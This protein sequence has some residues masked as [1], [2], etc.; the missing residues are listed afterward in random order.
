MAQYLPTAFGPRHLSFP[1]EEANAGYQLD[2]M[3]QGSRLIC[4]FTKQI[5]HGLTPYIRGRTPGTPIPHGSGTCAGFMMTMLF[6]P[7]SSSD[8]SHQLLRAC[9]CLTVC[10][11]VQLKKG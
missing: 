10:S 4:Q 7:I 5:R 2:L 3:T 1:F 9:C 11:L 8:C 6:L